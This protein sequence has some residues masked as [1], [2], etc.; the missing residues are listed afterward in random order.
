MN[1]INEWITLER[2]ST[3]FKVS[4]KIVNDVFNLNRKQQKGC[5]HSN[6][7]QSVYRVKK[8][9]DKALHWPLTGN[10]YPSIRGSSS[11]ICNLYLAIPVQGDVLESS[12]LA[13]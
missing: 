12:W 1:S 3:I 7:Q 10:T 13:F 2:M 4:V 8:R 9:Q 6:I 11:S 5:Q